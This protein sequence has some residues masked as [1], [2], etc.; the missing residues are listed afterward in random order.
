MTIHTRHP[1]A[2]RALDVSPL[3]SL[4]TREIP[5]SHLA[6]QG[7]D[8]ELAASIVADELL[9]DGHARLNLATFCATASETAIDALAA[10]ATRVNVINQDEY[11]ASVEIER[12]LCSMVAHLWHAPDHYSAVATTGSSEAIQLAV[13]AARQ[14][15]RERGGTGTPNLVYSAAAHPCWDKACRYFDVEPRKLPIPAVPRT[16]ALE[17]DAVAA[18]VD[19]HTLMVAATLGYPAT[20]AFDDIPDIAAALD[21]VAENTG[22]NVGLHVDAASGGFTA[23]F[24]HPD[25]PWDFRTTRVESINASGH[26]YAGA[27]LG[28]GFVTWRDA[29]L[30]SNHLCFDVN[31]LGGDPV[32]SF[33]LT[34]SRPAAPIVAAYTTMMRLGRSGYVALTRR[35]QLVARMLADAVK[36]HG[37][38]LWG[39]GTQLPL[40]T[41]AMDETRPR[42]W[43][44]EHLSAK[45]RE[46]G[47]QLPVYNL[48]ESAST[49][50]ARITC[51]SGLSS[52]LAMLLTEHLDHA[53]ATLDAHE[54]DHPAA[55]VE[56]FHL[57]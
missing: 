11:P 51:R 16:A 12:R 22:I 49:L 41:F 21:A 34:F 8:P 28:L 25:L 42:K 27:P 50:V 3:Y 5:R 46:H 55:P 20:G 36:S 33:S 56:G 7:M 57:A 4:D 18:A 6:D 38:V 1:H 35:E 9:L 14:R 53:V 10:R 52:D 2:H 31:L 54:G 17:P 44:M 47:W 26:K 37:F 29:S 48:P 15:Y 23:P 13:L 30:L 32:K 24:T 40:V 43:G 39:E 45:L 19:E